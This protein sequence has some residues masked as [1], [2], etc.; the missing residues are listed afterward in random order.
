MGKR[1]SDTYYDIE[2]EFEEALLKSGFVEDVLYLRDLKQRKL[3][4]STNI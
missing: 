2:I 1:N 4:I 3:F